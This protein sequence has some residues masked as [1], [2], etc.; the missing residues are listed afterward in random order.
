MKFVLR[1][2]L[3]FF[4]SS[5]VFAQQQGGIAAAGKKRAVILRTTSEISVD[6]F[7]KE[8]DWD[9]TPPIGEVIQR[10]PREGIPATEKTDVRLLYDSENL[11]VGVYC[12]DSSP[13]QIIGTQMSRD[14]DL[15]A[16]DKIEILLDSFR[17]FRN[18]YY[19]ST[20]PLGALVDG[21]IVENG[22]LSR[23]WDAIWGV[24]TQRRDNGWTAEFAIPFKSLG[25][26]QGQ[27]VWGFNFSRT[28]KR[29]IE[30]DR[31]ASPQL[32]IQ[33]SQ[34]SQAGEIEGLDNIAQGVG[35]DVRPYFTGRM[36][37]SASSPTVT[38]GD[39]GLDAFYNITPSLKLIATLNT[40][41]AETEVDNRQINLTRFPLFFPEKRS[42]FLENLGVFSFAGAGTGGGSG[43]GPQNGADVI[44][45]FSRRIGLV[46]CREIPILGGLKLTGKAGPYD[47][48]ILDVRTRESGALDAKN[49]HAARI[50][51]NIWR[52]SYIG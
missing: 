23:D 50:K 36:I 8:S 27:P 3:P 7:L 49:F 2:I 5:A 26:R 15:S 34:V 1:L 21:L 29:K 17:D 38:K 39:S 41:F 48:G 20:N 47:L 32:D 28:I 44:P 6:G 45:F 43:S 11:Y 25:F 40:D 12:Y 37:D 52:E 42:F 10:E 14:S 46:S 9:R 35:L 31:W 13:D 4:L 18:A 19:F 16:D 51:R 30:E 24:R 22:N 33:F